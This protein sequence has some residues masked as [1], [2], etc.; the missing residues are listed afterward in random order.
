MLKRLLLKVVKLLD[1]LLDALYKG[2]KYWCWVEGSIKNHE[3]KRLRG[4]IYLINGRECAR[5]WIAKTGP[6]KP[7]AGNTQKTQAFL[8]KNVCKEICTRWM[9]CWGDS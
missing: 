5:C 1:I 9:E 4:N 3:G 6:F 7:S 2:E 8:S